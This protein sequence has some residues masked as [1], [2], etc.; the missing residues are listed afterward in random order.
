[1]TVEERYKKIYQEKL[2]K[3]KGEMKDLPNQI[4]E[5]V[6]NNCDNDRIYSFLCQYDYIH[7]QLDKV[8]KEYRE[9]IKT[10]P[11]C[12]EQIDCIEHWADSMFGD[13]TN[14]I[15]NK[16]IGTISFKVPCKRLSTIVMALASRFNWEATGFGFA[17]SFTTHEAKTAFGRYIHVGI[18]PSDKD[19]VLIQYHFPPEA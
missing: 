8:E 5:A 11:A 3:W 9:G 14:V 12:L 1:M 17:S 13:E 4:R 7:E 6:K 19:R 10:L 2:E 16:D 15:T 18:D